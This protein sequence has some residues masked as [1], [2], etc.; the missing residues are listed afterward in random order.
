MNMLRTRG[1]KIFNVFN[2]SFLILVTLIM[3]YPF[4]EIIRISLS[5]TAEISSAEFRLFPSEINLDAYKTVLS[6]SNIWMGYKNTIIRVLLGTTIEMIMIVITAYPLSKKFF[7]NRSMWTIFIVFTMFFSGGLIP[8]YLNIRNLGIDNSI[9]ALVLPGAIDTYAMLIVRNYF[10]SLPASLEE[11]AKI[12]GAGSMRVL[13]K[14]VL[15]V[16]TPILMT[17]MLWSIVRHWNAWFDCL[18]YIQEPTEYVLQAI[19]RKIVIDA[20]PQFDAS[21]V[22]ETQEVSNDA[23]IV[24]ASTIVVSTI[25]IMV[26]YPFIQK[27][28]AKGI[29]VGSLKG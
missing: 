11:A 5:T 15:P 24:K 23:E 16:S 25:P 17:V 8:I 4:W 6:N 22:L 7:P 21:T 2:V 13:V 27:Y 29:L 20:A 18:I 10:M 14:I 19:L 1:E 9:W 28:F 12:D 26:F 3:I